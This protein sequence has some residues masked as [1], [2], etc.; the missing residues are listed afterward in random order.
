MDSNGDKGGRRSQIPSGDVPE[1][2]RDAARDWVVRLAS[3]EMSPGEHDRFS[4]WLE[5]DP[6][7]HDAFTHERALWQNAEYMKDVFGPDT[8]NEPP[9]ERRQNAGPRTRHRARSSKAPLR[10]ASLAGLALVAGLML[11]VL[12]GEIALLLRADHLTA[13]GEQTK[14]TLADGSVAHLNTDTAIDVDY[15]QARRHITLL[16]G[17]AHFTVAR[18]TARPFV[19]QSR[20]RNT[21]AVGTAFAVRDNDGE[22]SV[23][24]TEG[25]IEVAARHQA[26][27]LPPSIRLSADQQIVYRDGGKAS[28]VRH[29]DTKSVLGWREGRIV[30][31]ELPFDRAIAE[32]DRYRPGRIL[33][34]SARK[35]TVPVSGIF[36]KDRLDSAV[37]VLAATQGLTVRRITPYLVVLH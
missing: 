22:V 11:F 26:G 5:A 31:D 10:M 19:V 36:S 7:H 3:G 21:R 14:I 1:R 33:I 24:V 17:E 13:S 34:A 30:I 35:M 16:R 23:T 32:L 15:S 27:E 20:D 8:W 28:G 4:E 6:A 29:V 9:A 18:N 37:N 12:A 25:E 2:I